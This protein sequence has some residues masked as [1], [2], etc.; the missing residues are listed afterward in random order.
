MATWTVMLCNVPW[1]AG[2][3]DRYDFTESQ[4]DSYF[5]NRANPKESITIDLDDR[6]FKFSESYVDLDLSNATYESLDEITKFNYLVLTTGQIKYYYFI[7]NFE[8]INLNN[9]RAFLTLDSFTTFYPYLTL[10][11]SWVERMH[12]NMYEKVGSNYEINEDNIKYL[13]TPEPIEPSGHQKISVALHPKYSGSFPVGIIV[14]NKGSATVV[15]DYSLSAYRYYVAPLDTGYTYTGSQV[16]PLYEVLLQYEET[17]RSGE[18]VNVIVLPFGI[19]SL[20]SSNKV[21]TESSE[22]SLGY[23]SSDLGYLLPIN[24]TPSYLEA[25]FYGIYPS[26][27][28]TQLPANDPKYLSEPFS[29]V[30]LYRGYECVYTFNKYLASPYLDSTGRIVFTYGVCFGE[31]PYD[32][33]Y[34][35]IGEIDSFNNKVNNSMLMAGIKTNYYEEYIYQTKSRMRAQEI[36]NGASAVFSLAHNMIDIFGAKNDAFFAGRN[37]RKQAN[38]QLKGLEA[39]LGVV[40]TVYDFGS[41]YMNRGAMLDDLKRRPGAVNGGN[42][43][44][45]WADPDEYLTLYVFTP[46]EWERD[47]ILR[48]MERFGTTIQEFTEVD[49]TSRPIYNYVKTRGLNFTTSK[50]VPN[51]YVTVIKEMFDLGVTLWHYNGTSDT[52]YNIDL[53][54]RENHT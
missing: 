22:L 50:A 46:Q 12:L 39:G 1:Q 4:R 31:E 13:F 23:E 26:D 2:T 3:T 7:D 38:A 10:Q 35:H 54:N 9:T 15:K 18:V 36:D 14:T 25:E 40:E 47:K 32:Y 28:V 30:S 52:M 53:D 29:Y 19:P 5:G 51:D 34:P 48:Y 49:T 37:A 27:S 20:S 11:P 45:R 43:A 17:G 6:Q 44:Y 8:Y 16:S 42:G 21:I 33:V 41:F 24:N